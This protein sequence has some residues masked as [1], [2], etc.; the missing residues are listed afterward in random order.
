M[1][2]LQIFSANPSHSHNCIMVKGKHAKALDLLLGEHD[3][4]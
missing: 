2:H 1:E 4:Q 3:V